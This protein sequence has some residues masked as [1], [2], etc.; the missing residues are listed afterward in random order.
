CVGNASRARASPVSA[1]AICRRPSA[2]SF[3]WHSCWSPSA[4]LLQTAKSRG[5]CGKLAAFALRPTRGECGN[6]AQQCTQARAR[7]RETGMHL[8]AAAFAEQT[9]RAEVFAVVGQQAIVVFAE[10]R[11][12]S[13][14]GF[15]AEELWQRMR[16]RRDRMTRG[17][18]F[19][20][21][22]GNR[23]AMRGAGITRVV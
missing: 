15:S 11:T 21:D 5:T 17:K 14:D 4:V 23:P 1:R 16:F 7:V 20:R 13:P 18:L 22:L 2:A 19:E 10:A 9:P 12:G 3:R 8:L 6:Q